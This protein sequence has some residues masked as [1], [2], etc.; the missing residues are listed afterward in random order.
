MNRSQ[1]RKVSY[2]E[3]LRKDNGQGMRIFITKLKS[4]VVM[5]FNHQIF[6]MPAD[7]KA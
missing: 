1:I 3:G 5:N 2:Q 6:C 7:E 4:R